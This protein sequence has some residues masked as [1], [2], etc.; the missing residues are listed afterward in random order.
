MKAQGGQEWQEYAINHAGIAGSSDRGYASFSREGPQNSHDA[1]HAGGQPLS[2][3]S[4][5]LEVPVARFARV[6][7]LRDVIAAWPCD[8]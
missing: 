4:R 1:T 7:P 8:H 2:G 3:A 5:L 6:G